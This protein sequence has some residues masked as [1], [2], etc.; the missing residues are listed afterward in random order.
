M[1]KDSTLVFLQKVLQEGTFLF[2]LRKKQPSI[3]TL[4]S[5]IFQVAEDICQ[6]KDSHEGPDHCTA[7]HASGSNYNWSQFQLQRSVITKIIYSLL[8]GLALNS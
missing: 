3:T 7:I 6:I 4:W 5:S 2:N 8:M 1:E